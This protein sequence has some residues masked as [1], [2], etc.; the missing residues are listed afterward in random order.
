MEF[1]QQKIND[2]LDAIAQVH[3]SEYRAEMTVEHRGGTQVLVKYPGKDA[4]LVAL[5]T[6]ELMTK[7]LREKAKETA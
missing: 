3:G 2:F 7:N 4:A 1:V 5:D 6:L